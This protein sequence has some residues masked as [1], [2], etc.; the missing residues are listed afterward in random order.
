MKV[1]LYNTENSNEILF[2]TNLPPTATEE[3]LAKLFTEFTGFKEVRI[4]PGK[5]DIAFVEYSTGKQALAAKTVLD[6]FQITTT[7]A[8][9]VS[10]ADR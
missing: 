8:M 7:H 3:S 2:L 1:L 5:S 10:F 4:V 9:T 6:G